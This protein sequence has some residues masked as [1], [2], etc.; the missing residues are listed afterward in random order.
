MRYKISYTLQD[1]NDNTAT[2]TS[3]ISGTQHTVNA[4]AFSTYAVSIV[5]HELD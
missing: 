2:T 5:A 3:S 4:Q 1:G